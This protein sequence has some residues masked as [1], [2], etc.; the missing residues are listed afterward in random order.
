ME[1]TNIV[2]TNERNIDQL[3]KEVNKVRLSNKNKWYQITFKNNDSGETT[4][5][6]AYNTWIQLSE[7]PVFSNA[8][9]LTATEFKSNV[10]SGLLKL[11]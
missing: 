9:E 10:K 6:K 5:I 1:N 7:K 4:R 11:L 8:M 3:V 2:L